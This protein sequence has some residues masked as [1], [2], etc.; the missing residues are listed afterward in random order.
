MASPKQ[1]S[2]VRRMLQFVGLTSC[3]AVALAAQAAPAAADGGWTVV[4]GS[5]SATHRLAD[6]RTMPLK[7]GDIVAEGDSVAAGA[8]G[9]FV[10][11]HHDHA[12]TMTVNPGSQFRIPDPRREA[13]AATVVESAGTLQ[14]DVEHTPGRRFEV[15]GPYLAAVV[16]GTSFSVAVGGGGSTVNVTQGAVEVQSRDTRRTALVG[17]GQFA[18]VSAFGR[19]E[20]SV[21]GRPAAASPVPGASGAGRPAAANTAPAA[22]GLTA[23][24]GETHLDIGALTNNLVGNAGSPPVGTTVRSDL[25]NGFS[26][27]GGPP[28]LAAVTPGGAAAIATAAASNGA[29]QQAS[30]NAGGNGLALGLGSSNGNASGNENAGGNGN[31]NAGGNGNGNGNGRG[32]SNAGGNGNGGGNGNNGGNGLALG[33]VNGIGVGNGNGLNLGGSGSSG[34]G[35]SGPGGSGEDGKGKDDGKGPGGKGPLGKLVGGL[36]KH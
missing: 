2:N 14:F 17:P 10:L 1:S 34:S 21:G 19:H 25:A 30:I 13:N 31:G 9:R 22:Q 18:M 12:D 16:K 6:G 11:K 26:A 20:L 24:V 8:D 35:N 3:A 23:A 27:P 33:L 32:N 28:G 5:G 36:L 4:Q 7:A 29:P 15:D